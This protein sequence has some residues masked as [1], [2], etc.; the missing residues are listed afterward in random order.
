MAS[1]RIYSK[2]QSAFFPW[3]PQKLELFLAQSR[4]SQNEVLMVRWTGKKVRDVI[5]ANV[6]T[7]SD[8]GSRQKALIQSQTWVHFLHF[9]GSYSSYGLNKDPSYKTVTDEGLQFLH[10]N[11]YTSVHT[12]TH[13]H[14]HTCARYRRNPILSHFLIAIDFTSDKTLK[15]ISDTEYLLCA[16]AMLSIYK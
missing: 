4:S 5:C 9:L 8:W 2:F 13:T 1:H 7:A 14:T 12:H 10:L 11:T 15:N 16:H 3:I 6:K